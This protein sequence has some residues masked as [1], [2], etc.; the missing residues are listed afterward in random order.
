MSFRPPHTNRHNPHQWRRDRLLLDLGKIVYLRRST[1]RYLDSISAAKCVE[2]L[3]D[4]GGG[5]SA[6]VD[7]DNR[8]LAVE[9]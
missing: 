4:F 9:W 2:V 5:E 7:L 3:S 1:Y 8:N 6:V